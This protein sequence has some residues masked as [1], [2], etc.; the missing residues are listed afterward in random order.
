MME[1]IELGE[2][3]IRVSRKAIK[4][5]HLTVHPPEGRVTLATPIDTRPEV[6]RAYAIS[7]LSWIR[8]QQ[9]QLLSLIHI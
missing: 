7:K 6:A 9:V 4:N 8:D 1:I 3:S 2:I 5:V